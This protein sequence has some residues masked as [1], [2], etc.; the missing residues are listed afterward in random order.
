[1]LL[2]VHY[3]HIVSVQAFVR[4]N[5][6]MVGSISGTTKAL[7]EVTSS[8]VYC[9]QYVRCCG[10]K[11]LLV[12]G[13]TAGVQIWSHDGNEMKFFAPIASL[14]EASVPSAAPLAAGES[15]FVR[16]IAS[17]GDSQIAVGCSSGMLFVLNVPR[18]GDGE[19]ISI[20]HKLNT[21]ATGLNNSPN[22]SAIMAVAGSDSMLVCAN[23]FGDIF[24]FDNSTGAWKA[25]FTLALDEIAATS[26][27]PESLA[28]GLITCLCT[29]TGTIVAG[30]T[31]GH[32]R[33]FRALSGSVAELAIEVSAHFRSVS[34]ITL[35]PASPRFA[36]CGEDQFV[37]VWEFPDFTSRSTSDADLIHSER[38]DN[39]MC[40]GICYYNPLG[41]AATAV[42][43]IAINSFDDE[44]MVVLIKAN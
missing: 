25:S 16:G 13:S 20:A 3:C 15:H 37:H 4:F 6:V 42:S 10:N 28:S 9:C 24:G 23:E 40:T 30:Y 33:V 32:M 8:T 12:V 44:D 5:D 7:P 18:D 26:G 43:N 21:V 38:L 39:R 35:N 11:S 29:R 17:C 34:G 27:A 14:I 22:D 31:T 41:G 36:T 1:M 19:G 2:I